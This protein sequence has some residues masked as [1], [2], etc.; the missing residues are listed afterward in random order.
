MI[1]HLNTKEFE[2]RNQW[3]LTSWDKST[4]LVLYDNTWVSSSSW[5][6]YFLTSCLFPSLSFLALCRLKKQ[7]ERLKLE[8]H[9]LRHCQLCFYNCATHS[10]RKF[11]RW[12]S[13][14]WYIEQLKGSLHFSVLF[15]F[16]Y[17]YNGW[18]LETIIN[19]FLV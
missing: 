4:I 8:H 17:P 14:S 9:V 12:R 10:S 18:D 15:W 3:I 6:L 7:K 13:L 5:V 11:N 1:T 16:W 2:H 19:I